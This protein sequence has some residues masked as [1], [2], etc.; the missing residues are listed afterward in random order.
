MSITRIG[1]LQSTR[2]ATAVNKKKGKSNLDIKS[3]DS[4]HPIMNSLKA[5]K[6]YF[7]SLKSSKRQLSKSGAGQKQGLHG[8]SSLKSRHEAVRKLQEDVENIRN[9]SRQ[10]VKQRAS[11]AARLHSLSI[12]RTIKNCPPNQPASKAILNSL[13]RSMQSTGVTYSSKQELISTIQK[14]IQALPDSTLNKHSK[15]ALNNKLDHLKI[16]IGIAEGQK[17][18]EGKN[19]STSAGIVKYLRKVVAA[20]PEKNQLE[21][22][23][24]IKQ[25]L[26]KIPL[27]YK[28]ESILATLYTSGST[29]TKTRS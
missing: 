12:Q 19:L 16:S 24:K 15:V 29:K 18:A 2:A 26:T 25:Q 13:S 23:D 17:F 14:D 9:I 10:S 1:H 8:L 4:R 27:E 21:L 6:F 5:P 28:T 3:A 20:T 22:R 11:S 7:S